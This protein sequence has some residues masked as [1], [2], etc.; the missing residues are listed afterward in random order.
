MARTGRKMKEGG[1]RGGKERKLEEEIC[2]C[3]GGQRFNE[4]TECDRRQDG[5][6][7]E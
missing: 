2:V 4:M 5:M 3:K 1:K 6:L 7:S